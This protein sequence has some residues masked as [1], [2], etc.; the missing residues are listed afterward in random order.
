MNT[1]AIFRV[2][3]EALSVY[4]QL[5]KQGIACAV[6]NTP[7]RLR[8]GCGLSVVFHESMRQNVDRAIYQVNAESFLGYFPR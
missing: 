8:L 2:R 3:S 5:K 6:V 4:K 1:L 7:S